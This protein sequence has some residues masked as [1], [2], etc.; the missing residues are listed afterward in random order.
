MS[1]QK[2]PNLCNFIRSVLPDEISNISKVLDTYAD[3]VLTHINS[4]NVFRETYTVDHNSMLIFGS[5]LK[6]I[7][8]DISPFPKYVEKHNVLF[9]P[10]HI[11]DYKMCFELISALE[12][13]NIINLVDFCKELENIF[14]AFQE[15]CEFKNERRFICNER[16]L[17]QFAE[18][19]DESESSESDPDGEDRLNN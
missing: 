10:Q 7:I 16:K 14:N 12:Q 19:D 6:D 5:I 11:D 8:Y 2:Y 17:V 9:D 15:E 18:E 13:D 3:I 1:E 4:L